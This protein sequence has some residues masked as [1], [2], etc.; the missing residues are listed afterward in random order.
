[1]SD[2][3]NAGEGGP[4]NESKGDR[5]RR[6]MKQ[7]MKPFIERMDGVKRLFNLKEYEFTQEQ[8]DKVASQF[9]TWAKELRE[10]GT[11][12]LAKPAA[13]A[14]AAKGEFDI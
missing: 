9:E 5:F 3:N 8:V 2:P 12:A 6:L 4:A 10:T 1:M 14:A 11:A 7:R 13:P